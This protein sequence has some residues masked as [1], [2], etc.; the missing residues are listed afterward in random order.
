VP[1]NIGFTIGLRSVCGV[2]LQTPSPRQVPP[3]FH[4]PAD[5]ARDPGGV[6]LPELVFGHKIQLGQ[7]KNNAMEGNDAGVKLGGA[8]SVD[9]LIGWMV[10]NT[11]LAT[12]F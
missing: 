2:Q 6:W 11:D 9:E 5:F 10:V 1:V 8:V 12:Y 4:P 3:A 7:C